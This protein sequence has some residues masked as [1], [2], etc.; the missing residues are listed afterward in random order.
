MFLSRPSRSVLVLKTTSFDEWH[1]QLLTCLTS[2][3]A[4]TYAAKS[5]AGCTICA[6]AEGCQSDNARHHQERLMEGAPNFEEEK[7]SMLNRQTTA[8]S[9]RSYCLCSGVWPVH[10]DH[11]GMPASCNYSSVRCYPQ[12]R[13]ARWKRSN[14]ANAFLET[15]ARSI[16]I[17]I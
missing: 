11:G 12:R 3:G 7:Q 1:S 16:H 5:G 14:Y 17:Y 15:M 8:A 6:G 13:P 2:L 10:H 4:V 9:Y